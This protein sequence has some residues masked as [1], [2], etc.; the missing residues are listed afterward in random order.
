MPPIRNRGKGPPDNVWQDGQENPVRDLA[1]PDAL[2]MAAGSG[3]PYNPGL[4]A[5]VARGSD[6]NKADVI[7]GK[8]LCGTGTD[9]VFGDDFSGPVSDPLIGRISFQQIVR[10]FQHRRQAVASPRLTLIS[11]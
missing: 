11:A 10:A 5:I 8:Q 3:R 4:K 2:Y 6:I 7:A 9:F 1:K